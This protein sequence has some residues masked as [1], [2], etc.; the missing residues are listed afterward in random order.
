MGFPV[1]APPGR[2][3]ASFADRDGITHSPADIIE[4]LDH[5]AIYKGKV[6]PSLGRANQ[7]GTRRKIKHIPPER[8]PF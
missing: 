4:S 3:R 1:H 8:D 2:D 7:T 5:M 6:W